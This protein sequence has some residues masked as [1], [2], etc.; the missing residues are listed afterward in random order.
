M[1]VRLVPASVSDTRGGDRVL[2]VLTASQCLSVPAHMVHATSTR[3]GGHA[4]KLLVT[5]SRGNLVISPKAILALVTRM[6]TT[7]SSTVVQL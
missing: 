3:G 5:S 4:C 7:H 2:S 6:H 1:C